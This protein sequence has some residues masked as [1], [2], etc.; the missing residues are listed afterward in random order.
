MQLDDTPPS[1]DDMPR[2]IPVFPLPGALLLP[3][4]RL[5]LNIFEP[6]YL[7]MVQDAMAGDRVIGMV[8]PSG[9]GDKPSLYEVGCAGLITEHEPTEDGRILITL[10]GIARFKVTEELPTITQYRQVQASYGRF[11]LDFEGRA[12]EDGV[13][14]ERLFRSLDAY[15]EMRGIEADW[16]A[17][18]NAPND[19]LLT[20]LAM[21]S[22][23]GPAEKQALL[24]AETL[25]DH[26]AVL[27]T[28]LE[29]A[30]AEGGDPA[31]GGKPVH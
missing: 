13:D 28:L 18:R 2:T 26:A 24:E 20:A 15:F 3:R 5:P 22:P 9:E 11:R 23:F 19:S 14:R 16:A 12:D 1:Y 10:T 17:I 6:R 8:Q 25:S 4:G 29:M 30:V 27:T 7:A 31:G 21:M